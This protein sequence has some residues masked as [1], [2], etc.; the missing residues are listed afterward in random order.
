MPPALLPG[1]DTTYTEEISASEEEA[2]QE[3]QLVWASMPPHFRILPSWHMHRRPA[4]TAQMA[5][6]SLS[7]P[8]EIEKALTHPLLYLH[9]SPAAGRRGR[10]LSRGAGWFTHTVS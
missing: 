8:L 10:S 3:T 7:F 4:L 2:N 1:P 6:K 5:A 9:P